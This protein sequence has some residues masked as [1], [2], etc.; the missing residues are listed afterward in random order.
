LCIAG[1]ADELK[2]AVA[3][4]TKDVGSVLDGA[5]ADL[6]AKASALKSSGNAETAA[7]VDA[8]LSALKS[9]VDGLKKA[10]AEGKGDA[11]SAIDQALSAASDIAK[12]LEGAVATSNVNEAFSKLAGK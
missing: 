10:V 6:T 1:Q 4:G 2:S 7:A 8:S 12:D 11:A 3:S 5:V 9:R